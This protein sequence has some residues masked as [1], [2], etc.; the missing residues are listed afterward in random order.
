MGS[1]IDR[2]LTLTDRHREDLISRAREQ[3]TP[4]GFLRAG[5]SSSSISTASASGARTSVGLVLDGTNIASVVKGSPAAGEFDGNRIE[6]ND[7][8]VSVDGKKADKDTVLDL[9][10]GTDEVGSHVTLK[11]RKHG[12]LKTTF[13]APLRRTEK[14]RIREV[15]TLYQLTEDLVKNPSKALAQKVAERATAV[16]RLDYMLIG[17]AF[18]HVS[19]LEALITSTLEAQNDTDNRAALALLHMQ[20]FL[21]DIVTRGAS[22]PRSKTASPRADVSPRVGGFVKEKLANLYQSSRVPDDDELR[23]VT[24]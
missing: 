8:L 22:T 23:Y 14:E 17:S 9:L 21:D 4:K 7:F 11:I 5:S 3:C 2:Y 16:E 24:W 18:E 15:A 13:D 1:S 10:R 6:P 12:T 20:G 19:A